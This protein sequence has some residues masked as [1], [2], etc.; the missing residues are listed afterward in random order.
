MPFCLNYRSQI[1]KAWS[2]ITYLQRVASF[3]YLGRKHLDILIYICN[4]SEE[5]FENKGGPEFLLYPQSWREGGS[6]TG[7]FLQIKKLTKDMDVKGLRHSGN[8]HQAVFLFNFP[9]S[10][11]LD[12]YVCV[13]VCVCIYS[14]LIDSQW[15]P[16]LKFIKSK[17]R[18]NNYLYLVV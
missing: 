7:S 13:C 2:H 9:F 18:Q 14:I 4:L 3:E 1:C 12:K 11:L 5:I 10:P 8:S 17:I 6:L 16:F 15:I